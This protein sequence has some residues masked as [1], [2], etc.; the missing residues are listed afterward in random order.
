MSWIHEKT[1]ISNNNCEKCIE[2]LAPVV[3][4]LLD[5]KANNMHQ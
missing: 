3:C 4:N 5:I 2:T 1:I